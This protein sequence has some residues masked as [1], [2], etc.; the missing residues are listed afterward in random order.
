M[1][2]RGMR[3]RAWHRGADSF[4]KVGAPASA[5]QLQTGGRSGL[6]QAIMQRDSAI[7]HAGESAHSIETNC[8]CC[9]EKPGVRAYISRATPC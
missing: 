7:M 6:L 1:L 4:A 9:T 3:A 5:R 2:L 8:K